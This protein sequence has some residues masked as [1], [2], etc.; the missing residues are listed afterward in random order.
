[1]SAKC[2]ASADGL[3]RRRRSPDDPDTDEESEDEDNVGS[4]FSM[5]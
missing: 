2:H 5:Q 1:M 4:A 3:P